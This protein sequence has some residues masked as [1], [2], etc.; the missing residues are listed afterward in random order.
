MLI[1]DIFPFDASDASKMSLTLNLTCFCIACIFGDNLNIYCELTSLSTQNI[2]EG[3]EQKDN[4]LLL[5][6]NAQEVSIFL[7]IFSYNQ[8]EK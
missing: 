2:G 1:A 3:L 6:V 7:N 4:P 8:N 5:T